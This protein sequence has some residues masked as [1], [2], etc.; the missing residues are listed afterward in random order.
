L[1]AYKIW[2]HLALPQIVF[3]SSSAHN[4]GHV[5]LRATSYSVPLVLVAVL[6]CQLLFVIEGQALVWER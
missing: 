4:R 6:R 5:G 3:V 1:Q 2:A